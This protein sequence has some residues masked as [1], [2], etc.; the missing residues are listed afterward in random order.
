MYDI[1]MYLAKTSE[2]SKTVVP[3]IGGLERDHVRGKADEMIDIHDAFCPRKNGH[4]PKYFLVPIT[5]YSD[6]L[7]QVQV[8]KNN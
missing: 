3:D 5:Y 2:G 1:Y 4:K 7:D 6:S 8:L